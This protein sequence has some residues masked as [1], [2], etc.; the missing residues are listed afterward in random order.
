MI[1][2]TVKNYSNN[3]II[4]LEE[5]NNRVANELDIM[6]RT[7]GI[8]VGRLGMIEATKV[9]LSELGKL[10][11]KLNNDQMKAQTLKALV[12]NF[13]TNELKLSNEEYAN[14]NVLKVW[15]VERA[16][17]EVINVTI[18]TKADISKINSY[19]KNLNYKNSNLIY[20]YVPNSLLKR[21]KGFESAAYNLRTNHQNG[22]RTRIRAGKNDFI[23]LVRQKDDFTPWS[24]IQQTIVPVDIDTKF[25]VGKISE[26]DLK[27]ETNNVR[28]NNVNIKNRLAKGNNSDNFMSNNRFN[29]LSIEESLEQFLVQNTI[30]AEGNLMLNDA[31]DDQSIF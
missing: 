18:K 21:F 4:S 7:L 14:T 1:K 17:C 10:D 9:K 27:I 12:Q 26:E 31:M 28:I 19:L 25:E 30:D 16:D 3:K 11:N 6:S 2:T 23:L 29:M 8:R 22:V 24:M 20:Q 5:K 13:I 15:Q